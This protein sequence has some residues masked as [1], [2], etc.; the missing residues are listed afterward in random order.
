MDGVEMRLAGEADRT[1]ILELITA[2]L[3]ETHAAEVERL[4]HWRWSE[5]PLLPEPGYR[6]AV[7]IWQGRV[8]AG[9]TWLPT[10]LVRYGEPHEACWGVDVAV[11]FGLLRQA[12]REALSRRKAEGGGRGRGRSRGPRRSAIDRV[13]ESA[14]GC[15]KMKSSPPVSPTRRGY[16]A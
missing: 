10:G 9:V 5:C 11:H 14:E 13:A 2:S 4:W 1:G 7:S 15:A 3:G 8:L 6:G 16:W 12:Y